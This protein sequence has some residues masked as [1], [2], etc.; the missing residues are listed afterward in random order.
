[1]WCYTR[2][3]CVCR[4]FVYHCDCQCI[5]MGVTR[6]G[7][8]TNRFDVLWHVL[9][10][11]N[12]RR[13]LIE[14]LPVQCI[15]KYLFYN[16]AFKIISLSMYVLRKH[17][18]LHI[19]PHSR[20]CS[21]LLNCACYKEILHNQLHFYYTNGTAL[22]EATNWNEYAWLLPNQSKAILIC[23]KNGKTKI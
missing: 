14:I 15:L 2:Q 8:I 7:R 3:S 13:K 18:C 16:L 1:M 11:V 20:M 17:L 6:L 19:G 5:T 12:F 21:R 9:F 22:A 23:W 4:I 10:F